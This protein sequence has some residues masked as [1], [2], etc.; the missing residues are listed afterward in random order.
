MQHQAE[1]QTTLRSQVDDLQGELRRTTDLAKET[2]LKE[3]LKQKAHELQMA[4]KLQN[5]RNAVNS[6]Q[7]EIES[8]RSS[9]SWR[10]RHVLLVVLML[11]IGLVYLFLQG[12]SD[13]HRRLEEAEIR[14][15]TAVNESFCLPPEQHEAAVL[16]SGR[17]LDASTAEPIEGAQVNISVL[18]CEACPHTTVFTDDAGAF[19]ST[20][21]FQSVAHL[22]VTVSIKKDGFIDL[23]KPLDNILQEV[24]L[25]LSRYRLVPTW[26]RLPSELDLHVVVSACEGIL[27]AMRLLGWR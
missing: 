20:E 2:I 22:N 18:D 1:I 13:L 11:A 19:A 16:P 26:P 25:S 8:L 15:N 3:Q 10:L 4:Q 17:L 7:N 27:I 6:A 5:Q 14:Y 9:W 12:F 23:V 24:E 21:N